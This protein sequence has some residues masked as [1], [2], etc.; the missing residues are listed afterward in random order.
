MNCFERCDELRAKTVFKVNFL[1]IN[2]LWN[3]YYFLMFNIYTF[4][5]SNSF[6]EIESFN[7]AKGFGCVPTA[8]IFPNKW[9]IE[10]LFN[11]CPD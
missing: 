10:A 8:T 1:S 4:D 6:W 3:E 9:R 11:S 7:F 5:R 2:L